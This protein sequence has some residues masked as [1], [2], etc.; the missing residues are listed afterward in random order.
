MYLNYPYHL[1]ENKLELRN[2]GRGK[3]GGGSGWVGLGVGNLPKFSEKILEFP[4]RN[5]PDLLKFMYSEVTEIE[6]TEN[7]VA[8]EI[9]Y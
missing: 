8:A 4:E 3:R 7:S 2:L 1:E 5:E 6:I 9:I